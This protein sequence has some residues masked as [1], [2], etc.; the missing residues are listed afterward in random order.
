MLLDDGDQ[1]CTIFVMAGTAELVRSVSFEWNSNRDTTERVFQLCDYIE[2]A[3][4][5]QMD[6]QGSCEW[7]LTELGP[8]VIVKVLAEGYSEIGEEFDGSEWCQNWRARGGRS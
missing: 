7:N 2:P 8:G 4:W 6:S 5:A 1:S 3:H